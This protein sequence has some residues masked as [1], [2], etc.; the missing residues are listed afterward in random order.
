MSVEAVGAAVPTEV[1]PD[2]GGESGIG[3]VNAELNTSAPAYNLAGQRVENGFKGMVIQN[4]KKFM[5]K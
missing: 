2:L 1:T 5:V 4:G 3:N